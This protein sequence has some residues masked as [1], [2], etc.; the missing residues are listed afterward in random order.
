MSGHDLECSGV[1]RPY[2]IEVPSIECGDLP[3]LMP[4]CDRDDARVGA[5]ERQVDVLLDE[6]G[7]PHHVVARKWLDVE[8]VA[9]NSGEEVCLRARSELPADE[10]GG[11]GEYECCGDNRAG[12]VSEQA[13]TRLVVGV[14]SCQPRRA[15]RRCRR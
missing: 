11:L 4:L 6:F 13:C 1:A 3:L 10:V 2:D 15:G 14:R 5:T 7:D 9:G 12:L 8:F